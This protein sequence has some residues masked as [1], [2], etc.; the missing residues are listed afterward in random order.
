ME[1]MASTG[2]RI[3]SFGKKEVLIGIGNG[4][5]AFTVVLR[6]QTRIWVGNENSS[7]PKFQT[8]MGGEQAQNINRAW[9]ITNFFAPQLQKS[10]GRE[11]TRN[12]YFLPELGTEEVVR[13]FCYWGL[14]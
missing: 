12:F 13:H 14:K 1:K 2:T 4:R 7:P 3:D 11:S 9:A 8:L 5:L 10:R 6:R